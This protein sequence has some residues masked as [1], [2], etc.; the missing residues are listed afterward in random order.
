MEFE[1]LQE[2]YHQWLKV[3]AAMDTFILS[4]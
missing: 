3:S 2:T 1:Y 4:F